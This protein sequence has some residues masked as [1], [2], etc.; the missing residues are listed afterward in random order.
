MEKIISVAPTEQYFSLSWKIGVRCNYDCMYC[1]PEW[2]NDN[3]KHHDLSALKA[4]WINIHEKTQHLGLP[5]KISFT[6]GEP[7]S[8][9]SFLPFISW[10]RENYSNSIY[11][12]LVTSNGSATTKYYTRLLQQGIDNLSLSIHSEHINEAK[13]F[14]TVI[15]LKENLLPGKFLH[16]NIMNEFWNQDRIVKYKAILDEHAISYNINEIDYSHQTRVY[17]IFKGKLNLA[18]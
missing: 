5:Y 10:L 8:S 15:T 13:F 2:H 17:P 9:K 18:I 12:L 4:A 7:T 3:S 6:G 16:V 1:P 11:R 14:E